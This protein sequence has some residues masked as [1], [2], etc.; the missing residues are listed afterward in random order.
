M[1]KAVKSNGAVNASVR[2]LCELRFVG[3]DR[4]KVD[5]FLTD[6]KFLT[7]CTYETLCWAASTYV[8]VYGDKNWHIH[9][10]IEIKA[11]Q[12]E[13]W[14]KFS[15]NQSQKPVEGAPQSDDPLA[16][17]QDMKDTLPQFR[18]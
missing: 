10:H 15:A 1:S 11:R 16:V 12:S 7:Q 6:D 18:T 3:Y 2:K 13:T 14:R 4:A 8:D 17:L 5:E 9:K